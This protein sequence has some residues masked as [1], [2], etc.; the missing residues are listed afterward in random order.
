MGR[1][2]GRYKKEEIRECDAYA[3]IVSAF[4]M[5]PCVQTLAHLRTMLRW[6]AM[7]GYRDDEDILIAGEEKT[8][9]LIDAMLKSLSEM[10]T[11]RKIHLGMD[12]AFYLGFWEL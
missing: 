5:I 6:P 10:Y 1:F 4:E 8:Y 11:S 9:Q 7:M 12:E 3:A 2:R